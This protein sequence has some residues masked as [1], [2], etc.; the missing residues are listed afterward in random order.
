MGLIFFILNYIF[1]MCFF[2][3]L[4]IC[5][6][7]CWQRK[8]FIFFIPNFKSNKAS[9]FDLNWEFNANIYVCIFKSVYFK[10][11]VYTLLNWLFTHPASLFV[12]FTMDLAIVCLAV[13]CLLPWIPD[14]WS[15]SEN[16]FATGTGSWMTKYCPWNTSLWIELLVGVLIWR[17]LNWAVPSISRRVSCPSSKRGGW[18]GWTSYI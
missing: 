10:M 15:F 18:W 2:F 12:L 14:G 4:Y 11:Y 6:Y 16:C 9:K 13:C 17:R 7:I 5:V 8:N 1:Y 3:I